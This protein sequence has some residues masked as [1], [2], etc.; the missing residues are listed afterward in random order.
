MCKFNTFTW[1]QSR[2]TAKKK[3]TQK[4]LQVERIEDNGNMD[5]QKESILTPY[6][7]FAWKE[8]IMIHLMNQRIVQVKLEYRYRTDISHRKIQVLK[9][10]G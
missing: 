4:F 5:F 7:Y 10:Y 9:S 2:W 8:R 3:T 6:N 1:Y